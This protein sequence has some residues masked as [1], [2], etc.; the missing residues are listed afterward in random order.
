MS[1]FNT[2]KPLYF[3]LVPLMFVL[4]CFGVIAG[5]SAFD[6]WSTA[7]NTQILRMEQ[8]PICAALL[9]LDPKSCT[10]FV[11]GKSAG[12]LLTL[13]TL[14]VLLKSGYQHAMLVTGSVAMFQLV[15]LMYLCL[16]DPLMYGLPNFSLL[17]KETPESIF[18]LN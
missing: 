6:A 15:L 12:T 16:S 2:F 18:E 11:L 5:V 13:S 14:S 4:L 9:R 10:Y 8:N 17:F 7:A 1:I 3:R